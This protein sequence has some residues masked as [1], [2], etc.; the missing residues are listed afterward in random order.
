MTVGAKGPGLSDLLAHAP[1]TRLDCA[2]GSAGLMR[3]ALTLAS[4]QAPSRLAC[5]QRMAALPMP[6]NSLAARALDSEAALLTALAVPLA[7]CAPTGGA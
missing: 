7:R 1:L 5:G 6:T 2:A 4:K 3:Q